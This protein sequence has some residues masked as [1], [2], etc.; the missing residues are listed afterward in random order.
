M[1]RQETELDAG[2]EQQEQPDRQGDAPGQGTHGA[3]ALAAVAHQVVEGLA[4]AG[5]DEQDDD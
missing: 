1:K 5:E 4:Q 2:H 3:V